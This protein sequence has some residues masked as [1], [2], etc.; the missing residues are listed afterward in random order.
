MTRCYDM[1]EERINETEHAVCENSE[2]YNGRH[3]ML[4][5]ENQ[6]QIMRALRLL[7]DTKI[8]IED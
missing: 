8:V 1:L 3:V 2:E 5:L 7:L 6:M 4:I